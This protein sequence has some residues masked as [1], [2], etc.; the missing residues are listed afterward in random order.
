MTV[1]TDRCP[2]GRGRNGLCP[3]CMSPGEVG[4][5]TF[6]LSF[7]VFPTR[8]ERYLRQDRYFGGWCTG[9]IKVQFDNPIY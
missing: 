9:K 3:V 1:E 6:D 7:W 2:G 5:V 4:V 8:S